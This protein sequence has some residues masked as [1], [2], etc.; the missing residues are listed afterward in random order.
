MTKIH[1]ILV[2]FV[3]C[4]YI[5]IKIFLLYLLNNYFYELFNKYFFHYKNIY[6]WIQELL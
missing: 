6:K 4:I 3:N 2:V 1:Q 5:L